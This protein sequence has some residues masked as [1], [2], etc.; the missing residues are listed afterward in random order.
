M[1]LSDVFDI[2]FDLEIKKVSK[3]DVVAMKSWIENYR[4]IRQ[5]SVRDE[6]T[7]DKAGTLPISLY[8]NQDIQNRGHIEFRISNEVRVT[9]ETMNKPNEILVDEI[10]DDSDNS[11][12][13]DSSSSSDD[14]H[15]TQEQT[16]NE[17][18]GHIS[19]SGR[20]VRAT[21]RLDL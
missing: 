7:K 3:T 8:R 2:K 17:N 10:L 15:D 19:R 1:P 21:V 6:T 4:P 14:S 9:E 13:Y 20:V 18:I 5:R 16:E 12:E 11:D